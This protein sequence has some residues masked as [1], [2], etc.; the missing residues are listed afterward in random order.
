MEDMG[1]TLYVRNKLIENTKTTYFDRSTVP[2][3]SPTVTPVQPT[4]VSGLV[5]HMSRCFIV[6]ALYLNNRVIS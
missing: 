2:E 5:L 3:D 6:S 1:I 4:D